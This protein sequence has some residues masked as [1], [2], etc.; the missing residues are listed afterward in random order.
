[1]N[2]LVLAALCLGAS[3]VLFLA[4]R[5]VHHRISAENR[6][7]ASLVSQAEQQ[8][9]RTAEQLGADRAELEQRRATAQEQP[10]DLA[11]RGG[12]GAAPAHSKKTGARFRGRAANLRSPAARSA[13]RGRVA[14][15]QALF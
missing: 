1:M 10:A 15:R 13:A 6:R 8:Q 2:N 11:G 7:P 14:G 4:E 3:S 9:S 12:G 5:A